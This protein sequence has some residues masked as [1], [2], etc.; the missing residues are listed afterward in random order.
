MYGPSPANCGLYMD[1][2]TPRRGRPGDNV[3]LTLENVSIGTD[4]C[5]TVSVSYGATSLVVSGVFRS[6]ECVLI[7]YTTPIRFHF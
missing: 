2:S 3:Q 5:Y 6:C 4:Y 7:H 1:S